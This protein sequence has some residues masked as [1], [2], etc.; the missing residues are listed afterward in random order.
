MLT[1]VCIFTMGTL[2]WQLAALQLCAH[3]RAALR[4]CKLLGPVNVPEDCRG[5]EKV[6][7]GELFPTAMAIGVEVGSLGP[8]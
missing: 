4:E 3:C 2:L 8:W 7:G 5:R 6:K 1:P